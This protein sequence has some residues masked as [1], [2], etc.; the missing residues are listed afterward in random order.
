MRAKLKKSRCPAV[1]LLI[2]IVIIT[3]ICDCQTAA[4]LSPSALLLCQT[5]SNCSQ[6]KENST[7]PRYSCCSLHHLHLHPP[8]LHSFQSHGLKSAAVAPPHPPPEA[9][10]HT[11]PHAHI[12][13]PWGGSSCCRVT[14]HHILQCAPPL[15]TALETAASQWISVGGGDHKEMLFF[16]PFF[17]FLGMRQKF[18]N[19]DFH[20][21]FCQEDW[22]FAGLWKCC[23][24]DMNTLFS[25][26][27]D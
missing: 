26:L 19:I 7:S 18:H 10:P 15:Q 16:S 17:F 2:I 20:Q 1:P 23:V 6:R 24:K 21:H 4:R 13:A 8:K 9:N 14:L 5:R 22:N 25:L 12:R 11:H 27:S 3:I